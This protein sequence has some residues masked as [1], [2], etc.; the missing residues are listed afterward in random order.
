[1]KVQIA[2]SILS[3]DFG[4]LAAEVKAV[5]DAGAD[6][7]HVDVMDGHFVPNITLGPLIVKAIKPVTTLPLDCHLMISDPDSYIE[8]FADAGADWITVHVEA[9]VHLHR[10]IQAIK[11]LGVKA[12]AVLNPATPLST[13]D[14]VLED[15][16]LV[17]LMSVNPGFGGQGFIPSALRKIRELKA[18]IQDRGLDIPIE[19]DG[20]VNLKTIRDVAAAGAE[21][22][23]A[24][25]AVYKTDDYAATIRALKKA[26]G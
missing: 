25:S 23:V 20:G 10:T 15:L 8:A 19:V 2:P 26:A 12:G 21:I 3:A 17:L 18:M 13:L 16:D 24:G 9:C 11:A 14:Y 6:V 7:I 1:M 22:C 4:R 5:E